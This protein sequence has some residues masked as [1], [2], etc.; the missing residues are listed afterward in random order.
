MRSIL[1]TLAL[2]AL[3]AFPARA[4][5]PNVVTDIAPVQSLAAQLMGDL[6]QPL[7]LLDPNADPHDFQMR[8]SQ[9]RAMA[10]A[11][12]VIWMGPALTP[13]MGRM[14]GTLG[15]GEVT[16]LQLLNLPDLPTRFSAQTDSSPQDDPAT[17]DPHAWL[18]PLNAARFVAEIANALAALDPENAAVY[19]AN[20]ARAT[21]RIDTMTDE[22]TTLLQ[23]ARHTQIVTYHDAYR[24][25]LTR[26][27]LQFAGSL[28]PSDAVPPSAARIAEIRNLLAANPTAC[29][30]TEPGA[31][32]KLIEAVQPDPGAPVTSLGPLD[33]GQPPGPGYY[34][35]LIR[36]LADTIAA[37]AIR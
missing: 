24:Y 2:L 37:C 35:A 18:D 7:L 9:G 20:A 3:L 23:P 30:F 10:N 25:F 28:A 32:L 13:W 36:R 11:D 31:N 26:F 16:S 12:L 27:D 33:A 19:R 14:I 22:L 6:G 5:V 21:A 29:V 34:E 8:P 4:E 15:S 17:A 1:M